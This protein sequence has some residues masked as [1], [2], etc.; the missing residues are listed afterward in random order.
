MKT[1]VLSVALAAF[2]AGLGAAQ[3]SEILAPLNTAV[4][5]MLSAA[6]VP[7]RD[8]ARVVPIVAAGGATVGYA[9]I[10]G[11]QDRKSVV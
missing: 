5:A 8:A 9:Q 6:G 10:V 3:Q 7:N 4:D 1:V 2:A 11:P